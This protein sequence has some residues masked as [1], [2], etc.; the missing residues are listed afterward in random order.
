MKKNIGLLAM[1]IGLL[2]LIIVLTL[3][4]RATPD[5]HTTPWQQQTEANPNADCDRLADKIAA[6]QQLT[7]FEETMLKY[8][9]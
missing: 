9:K 4:S 8:C 1:G 7:A 3:A 6:H 2:A 5:P